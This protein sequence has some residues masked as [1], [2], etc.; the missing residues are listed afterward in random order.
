MPTR[1]SHPFGFGLESPTAK[2]LKA[3]FFRLVWEQF[4]SSTARGGA[5]GQ[6]AEIQLYGRG[7]NP[8]VTLTSDLVRLG[9]SRNLLSTEWDADKNGD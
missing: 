2:G 8:E 4:E 6:P 1:A 5:T 7:F 9:G 3:R